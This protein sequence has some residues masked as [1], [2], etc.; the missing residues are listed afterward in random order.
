LSCSCWN[1]T[2]PF[3]SGLKVLDLVSRGGGS[4]VNWG[5]I[6]G[7]DTGLEEGTAAE[8]KE[9]CDGLVDIP[10]LN[11]VSSISVLDGGVVEAEEKI[12]DDSC[13]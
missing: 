9:S 12:P 7:L 6:A 1:V 10:T 3:L 4:K 5:E 8:W 2:C 11:T 13:R